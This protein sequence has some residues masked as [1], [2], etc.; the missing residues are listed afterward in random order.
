MCSD[1]YGAQ[2]LRRFSRTPR[3]YTAYTPAQHPS[4]N[5]IDLHLTPFT[6]TYQDSFRGFM[7]KHLGA[8]GFQNKLLLGLPI[9]SSKALGLFTLNVMPLGAEPANA[10]V[11]SL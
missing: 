9:G 10:L 1:T 11:H 3:A 5:T 7:G 8:F 4:H 6:T 2:Q